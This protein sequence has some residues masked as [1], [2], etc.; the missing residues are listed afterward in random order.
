MPTLVHVSGRI[1]NRRSKRNTTR[2]RCRT[3]THRLMGVSSLDTAFAEH[4][5]ST[6][7]KNFL[8]VRRGKRHRTIARPV[9]HRLLGS[10]HCIAVITQVGSRC[11]RLIIL[12]RSGSRRKHI[13]SRLRYLLGCT[14]TVG[15]L[16]FLRTHLM[17]KG[18]H[19]PLPAF[20]LGLELLDLGDQ[21]LILMLH[22]PIV[23][24]GSTKKPRALAR[25][26]LDALTSWKWRSC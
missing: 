19:L 22:A 17:L 3:I 1:A 10:R 23:A 25:G 15:S 5:A 24:R 26:S 18:A 13:L 4:T 16:F 7:A 14:S 21:F 11:I 9:I 20:Q 8:L 6:I 12:D 2:T